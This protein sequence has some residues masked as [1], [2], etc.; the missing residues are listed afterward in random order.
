MYLNKHLVQILKERELFIMIP[1]LSGEQKSWVTFEQ[2]QTLPSYSSEE[3]EEL[4]EYIAP[5]LNQADVQ[6]LEIQDLEILWP[7]LKSEHKSWITFEQFQTMSWYSSKEKKEELVQYIAPKLNQADVQ[8]LERQDLEILIPHLTDEQKNWVTFEQFQTMPWYSSKEKKEELA[9]YIAP[10]LNQADVQSLEIQDLEI[11]WPHLKS[12]HKSW[13]TFEQFQTMS[14]YSSKEKKEELVQYIAPKLNQAD[15][16][17]LERQDLEILIPHLTDEQKNWVTFEQFQTMPWYSSK[18]KKEELAQY[19]APKLN[20]ADIQSLERQDLEILLPHLT[21]KQKNWVTSEQFNTISETESIKLAVYL[22]KHLVQG[23]KERGLSIMISHLSGEQKSWVTF[24]QFQ[25]IPSY[26]SIEKE[27]LAE[28]I[29]PKLNQADVQSLERQDLEILVPHLTDKQ[30]NWI[31]YEQFNK[32]NETESIKLTVYLN[33]HLVQGLKERGLSIMIPHLSGEQKSWVTFEQFQ[34]LPS[35]SSKE[36]EE[37]VEYIVPKLNQAEVQSLGKEDLEI[38]WPHL[39]SEHKSWI[40][41][42]QFQTMPSYSSE[43]KEE[44]AQYIAPKLNQADVQSLERQDLEILL[45]HLTDEQ[46]NWSL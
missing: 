36:K 10:K 37:L 44:L 30:K 38:L 16:Q 25:T 22:N 21:D 12:E 34:T 18:E 23:L 28:Y 43:K 27:E 1:H 15:V 9:Q 2:F 42:E 13:I 5:K 33:K 19:I 20:Q 35:Y 6:S 8:S 24:E 46:K 4:V 29:A 14:W 26:S 7:H 39:K 11:L 40:T 32:I 45:P 31:P 3:K 41:F 17:S